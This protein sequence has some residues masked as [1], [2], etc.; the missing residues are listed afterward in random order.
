MAYSLDDSWDNWTLVARAGNACF[1]LYVRCGI[2]VARNLT[3]GFIPGEIATSYGSPEQTRKLVDVELW[4]PEAGGYQ[5]LHY[6][7]RNPTAEKVRERQKADA[8][9]KARWRD[10]AAAKRGT[11]DGTRESAG[12]HGVT[13]G[14]SPRS[15]TPPKGGRVPASGAHPPSTGH[16][17]NCP[18]P[19]SDP[20][21]CTV[22]RSEDLGMPDD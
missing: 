22:C 15:P 5:D 11:R 21:T 20:A 4:R 10:R 16:H 13:D 1:G 6:H 18:Y 12:S 7:L 8:D 9:R 17:R 3:D 14:V 19:K 2:W